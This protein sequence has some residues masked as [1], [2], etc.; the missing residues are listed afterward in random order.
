MMFDYSRFS[1][2]RDSVDSAKY[3]INQKILVLTV[4]ERF[5]HGSGSGFFGIKSGFSADLDPDRDS[6]KQVR[7]GSG[8]VQYR[9]APTKD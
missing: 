6:G 2:N 5:F 1:R 4:L 8:K 7:S 3:E 9:A